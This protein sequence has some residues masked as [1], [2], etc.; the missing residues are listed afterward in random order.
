LIAVAAKDDSGSRKAGGI[1]SVGFRIAARHL[2]VDTLD[3][4]YFYDFSDFSDFSDFP[5]W[6]RSSFT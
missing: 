6:P 4:K 1:L 2:Q 3:Y 5:R